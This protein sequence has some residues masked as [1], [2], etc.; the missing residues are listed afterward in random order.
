MPRRTA[1]LICDLPDDGRDASE[2]VDVLV[3][4]I[5]YSE[6]PGGL[7]LGHIEGVVID[8]PAADVARALRARSGA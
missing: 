3:Q 6:R 1:I 7:V 4:E 2:L 5:R 8:A